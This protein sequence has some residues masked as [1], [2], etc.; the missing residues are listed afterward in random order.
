MVNIGDRIAQLIFEK[1]KT[2]E[3][4]ETDNLEG[5]GRGKHGYGST[6]IN[7]EPREIQENQNQCPSP[8]Q[9]P[10]SNQKSVTKAQSNK[11]D[12]ERM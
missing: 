8:V 1:I 3:I 2:P 6:G 5:T 10:Y 11:N 9:S 7:V 12:Q 4:K